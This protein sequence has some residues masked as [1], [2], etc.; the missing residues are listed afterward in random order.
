MLLLIVKPI[1]LKYL[2]I[3]SSKI[4]KIIVKIVALTIKLIN[5]IRLFS[6]I[7]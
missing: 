7:S 3:L 4:A 6:T 2:N 1:Y 5:K